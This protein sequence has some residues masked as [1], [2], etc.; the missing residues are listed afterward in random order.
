MK[1]IEKSTVLCW[2]VVIFGILC[3]AACFVLAFCGLDVPESLGVTA[4]GAITGGVG[5]Y[6][7][8]HGA[9]KNSRNKYGVDADGIP[10]AQKQTEDAVTDG[11]DNEH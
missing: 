9:L 5:G 10:F 3:V 8:Y 11:E 2:V 1:K 7:G 4:F 6:L